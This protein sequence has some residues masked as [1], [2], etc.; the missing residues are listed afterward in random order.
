ME[1]EKKRSRSNVKRLSCRQQIFKHSE[2]C[3]ELNNMIP[4]ED[5]AEAAE[6]AKPISTGPVGSGHLRE[7]RAKIWDLR[8]R[9]G[10]LK[11]TVLQ[12]TWIYKLG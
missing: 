7:Y 5:F 8:K 2:E 3:C 1:E 12:E 11:R 4:N 10:A 9:R 6:V